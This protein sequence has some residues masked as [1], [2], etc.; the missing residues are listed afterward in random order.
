MVHT[1]DGPQAP[2]VTQK[3]LLA[4]HKAYVIMM[5]ETIVDKTPNHFQNTGR[6]IEAKTR[7]R[8]RLGGTGP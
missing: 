4:R 1:V 2:N 8:A 6:W 5:F 7:G 3:S